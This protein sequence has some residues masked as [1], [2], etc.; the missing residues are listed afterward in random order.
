MWSTLHKSAAAAVAAIALGVG[1]AHA[2]PVAF[3]TSGSFTA[4]G[5]DTV[6]SVV[7]IPLPIFPFSVTP[8]STLQANGGSNLEVGYVTPAPFVGTTPVPDT[9]GLFGA[10]F[11][12]GEG[13]T[14]S[15]AAGDQFTLSINESVPGGANSSVASVTGT[16]SF[17]GGPP[18]TDSATLKITFAPNPLPVG[19]PPAFLY[20]ID[21]INVMI[22]NTNEPFTQI[23]TLDGS[24]TVAPLPATAS[25]GLGLFGVIGAVGGLNALRRR[26]AA[27]AL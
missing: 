9:T 11:L 26:R 22:A 8:V 7:S 17:L 24:V 25:M 10:F 12:H 16:V 6:S 23:I 2:D 4:A 27:A 3:T 14:Q 5:S 18:N 21:D 20:H 15:F 13:T 19:G 1:S